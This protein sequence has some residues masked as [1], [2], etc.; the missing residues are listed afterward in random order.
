MKFSLCIDDLSNGKVKVSRNF[1]CLF[2][3]SVCVDKI[4]L[5]GLV[6]SLVP[7]KAGEFALLEFKNN[8]HCLFGMKYWRNW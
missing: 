7:P 2:L 6:K 4:E 1:V 8:S 3:L 5:F